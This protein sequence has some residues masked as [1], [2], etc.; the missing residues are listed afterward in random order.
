[1][2]PV[3]LD[4]EERVEIAHEHPTDLDSGPSSPSSGVPSYLQPRRRSKS[5]TRHRS[6][7]T[8][9]GSSSHLLARLIA[10]DE[11]VR[12]VNA[13]L[14][15]TS[16]RLEN[17]STRANAAERR[18]LD[19]FNRLR[20]V[21]ESRERAEQESARLR[22]E[23]KLYKL[24]LEN[25]QKE[26]FRAQDIINEVSAQ[27]NEAEADA[28]RAR[29]KARKLQEEKLVMLAREDGRRQGYKEG[30]TIGRRIGYDQGRG[31]RDADGPSSRP[32]HYAISQEEGNE[33][34]END[35]DNDTV[36][37]EERNDPRSQA[38]L[39]SRASSR[40]QHHM[41]SESAPPVRTYDTAHHAPMLPVPT[42][43]TP[44]PVRSPSHDTRTPSPP[45]DPG[46]P[47]TIHPIPIRPS[48]IIP[49]HPVD[50]P[51][52]G[53]IPRADSRT[54][55]IPV[56]PPHEL[57]QPVPATPST[58]TTD[59]HDGG[60]PSHSH[61]H[62]HP[63]ESSSYP[64]IRTRDYAYQASAPAV[65]IQRPRTPSI[66]SRSSTHVSQYDLVSAPNRRPG[67]SLRNEIYAG[68][69]RSGSQPTRPTMS[70]NE[71]RGEQ[72]NRYSG[73][74]EAETMVEQWRADPDVVSTATPTRNPP[75][76]LAP[77]APQHQHQQHHYYP[78]RPREIVV[79]APLGDVGARSH[80]PVPMEPTATLQM[81]APEEESSPTRT[82]SPLEYLRQRFRQRPTSSNS[83]PNIVV[84]SPSESASNA[85]NEGTVTRP[86]LLSPESANRP[87]PPSKDDH[88][89]EHHR[90]SSSQHQPRQHPQQQQYQ[91]YLHDPTQRSA[92][93]S[94]PWPAGFM[95]VSLGKGE[96]EREREGGGRHAR[97]KSAMGRGAVVGGEYE[98]AP[99]P[100]GVTYPAPP[101]RPQTS[102]RQHRERDRDGR[103]EGDGERGRYRDG[104]RRR[105]REGDR[106]KDRD[107]D[108]ERNVGGSEEMSHSPAA[109]QR[110]I[111]LF[112]E[113]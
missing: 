98:M 8:T 52:D 89:Q 95:P 21:A 57:Q 77:S 56:P 26:I 51:H 36:E 28:A 7:T 38:R 61:S 33:G 96:R 99:L 112:D 50:V 3:D 54:S 22:E 81:Q 17:E 75:R 84:E 60:R 78:H 94:A 82:R 90:S 58:I 88:T 30:L 25:A 18:A 73:R 76:S 37:E 5:A 65:P 4:D 104:D 68:R 69:A 83:I 2:L 40:A 41:R 92:T 1:M 97:S 47:E 109:L 29:T 24:Q 9:E 35:N 20:T 103:A 32:R 79:P 62:R 63:P 101:I 23:L 67:S 27:R 80:T 55:Y 19:Y 70:R 53:W 49:H 113:S 12:E 74:S 48:P 106:G 100:P 87:L 102:H 45:R 64:P 93:P 46:E 111:S 110:P 85:S 10:R 66:I 39:R 16:E 86:E 44:L 31:I 105:D 14:V 91:Q 13:L 42:L 108:R 15:V 34:D 59:L 72:E 43:V 107:G 71:Y 6:H 11:E